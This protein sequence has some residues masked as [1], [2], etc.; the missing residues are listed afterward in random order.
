M[1]A[2]SPAI[3]NANPGANANSGDDTV[4]AAV[5]AC[6]ADFAV[7][8]YG[9]QA[10][11]E[12]SVASFGRL[13]EGAVAL[14][15]DQGLLALGGDDRVR[16][17]HS[18]T[19]ND[20]EHQPVAQARWHGL[21]TP[22]GRLLATMLA[23]RE[24]AVIR[25]LLPRPLAEPVRKR[26]S[27]YVLRAKVRVEDRSDAVVVFGLCGAPAAEALSSLGM[28]APGPY[29]VA[30]API[31][32]GGPSAATV[33]AIGLPAIAEP[34]G[35]AA[36]AA[37]LPRWLLVAPAASLHVLWTRLSGLLAPIGSA[38]WRW[39]DVRSGIPRVLPATVE[40]FVPQ[41]VNFDTVGGVSFDKGCYPGQEIVARSHYLG[42]VKRRLFL[43]HQPGPGPEPA[44]G[45]AVTA[46]EPGPVGVVVLAAPAPGG[47]VD[48]LFEAQGAAVAQA[49]ALRVDGQALT[50]G[51]LPYALTASDQ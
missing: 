40:Q 26:L 29:G 12:A 20:V 6:G 44:P 15:P 39:T 33:T 11:R 8:A 35:E 2:A 1:P 30:H 41:M 49:R 14:L 27:M 17:L 48:L 50:T 43:G 46:D 23:W 3:P 38:T 31:G 34:G 36:S 28:D 13:L 7:D 24:D 37:S 10:L 47:G 51:A 45:A 32:T 9:P 25:M 4:R 42:K 19:T 5:E 22:K 16:F 18:M 21:C